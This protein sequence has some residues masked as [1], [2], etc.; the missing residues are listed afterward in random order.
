MIYNP[1]SNFEFR[2]VICFLSG[3]KIMEEERQTVSVF[4][5]WIMDRYQLQ[6]KYISMLGGNKMKYEEMKLPASPLVASAIGQLDHITEKAFTT[7]YKA[8]IELP[9]L[10][11]FQ[12]MARI[13][14][15]AVYNDIIYA[16]GR[17]QKTGKVFK[18]SP[19]LIQ[20]LKNLHLM[21]QS[22]IRPV[23]FREFCPWSICRFTVNYSKDVFNYKDEAHKLNFCLG[24]NG[25]GIIACLQDNGQVLRNQKDILE[26]IGDQQLHPVQFE[27]LY[28]RFIYTN[29]LLREFPDYIVTEEQEEIV[30]SQRDI[31]EQSH[32]QFARWD[33]ETFAQVLANMWEPW[34][35]QLKDIYEFPNSPISYLIDESTYDFIKP[36]KIQLPF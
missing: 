29:Y 12:W 30:F 14:Y 31:P 2:D 26:K 34:G 8:V 18:L 9:E 3:E 22:L 5:K 17:Q 21:L 32:N 11:L 19:L 15:G 20:K 10:T 28:G 7:G 24:M 36:E 4:P 25:F 13:T 23:H 27:E 6:G 1:F 16:L 33:D 35:I